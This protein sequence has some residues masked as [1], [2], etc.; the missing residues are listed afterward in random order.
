MAFGLHE[1][2]AV[3]DFLSVREVVIG[4]VGISYRHKIGQAL[5]FF[6]LHLVG[7]YIDFRIGER[8]EFTAVVAMTI[9]QKNLCYLFGLVAQSAQRFHVTTNVFAC[10]GHGLLVDNLL[11]EA[12]G[13]TCIY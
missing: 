12:C 5:Q 3:A 1:P 4:S 11:R 13:Q 8:A 7:S 2:Y 6:G 9:G 10:I